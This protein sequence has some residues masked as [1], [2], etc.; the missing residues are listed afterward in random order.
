VERT[1]ELERK[2][3]GIGGHEM[4]K[5][6]KGMVDIIMLEYNLRRKSLLLSVTYLR[7]FSSRKPQVKRFL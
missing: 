6:I 4:E 5:R 1:P 2:R 3:S 7:K